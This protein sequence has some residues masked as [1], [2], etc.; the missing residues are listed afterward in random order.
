MRDMQK[1]MGTSIILITHDLGVVALGLV[2]ESGSGKSTTGRT[3][4]QLHQP[5]NGEVL[6]QDVPITRLTKIS[7]KQCVVIC[8]LF[9]KI[10]TPH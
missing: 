3:I 9:S 1:K 10:H 5:T 4:L 2:G 6:Y 8:K 7:L